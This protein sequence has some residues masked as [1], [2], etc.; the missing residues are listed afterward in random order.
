MVQQ[1]EA[2]ELIRRQ[3][4]FVAERIRDAADAAIG[5]EAQF[6]GNLARERVFEDFAEELGLA[7]Q[8]REEYT[9]IHGRADAVYNRF[10]IEYEPPQSLT[11]YNTSQRNQHA[12]G[13]VRQYIEEL[14]HKERHRVE[15]LAGVA[16]DGC[17]FIFA[18]FRNGVWH[19][20][21]P[22]PVTPASTE[23]FLRYLIS[24]STE[25]AL[26]ADNLVR[27]FGENKTVARLCVSTFYSALATTENPK[28][29]VIYEQWRQQFSE[30]CGFEEGSPRLDVRGLARSY[31][32]Q[33]PKPSA[34]KL[35]F[36]IH[37][38]YATFIKLL[39]VQV[40]HYYLAPKLGTALAQV[41]SY[42]SDRLCSYLKDME[43]GG[44]FRQ[45]GVAN[46]LEGD[47]FGWYL[48]VWDDSVDRAV[49][50][51]IAELSN[52][53][54][55]TLDVDPEQTRDLLKKLYQNVMPK[56][57]RH[58]LGEYYTPDWL[59]ERLL[60]QLG[61]T[62]ERDPELHQRRLL[63]P[64]CGSG[65]F[66][67]LAIKRVKEHCY[68]RIMPEHQILER[69]L[70][71]VVGFDLNPLAVIS[72][73][74]NYLL[75]LGE[76]IQHRREEINIPVY[77]CDSILT[78]WHAEELAGDQYRMK[79]L[80]PPCEFKTV[81]GRFAIPHSL[82]TAQYVDALA[83]LVE[84]CVEAKYSVEDFRRRALQTFPLVEEQ[85][86]SDIELLEKLYSRVKE[87]DEQGVNGIWARIIKNAFA[88]LFQGKFDYVA[89]NPPWVNWQSLPDGY[90]SDTRLLWQYHG[91]FPHGGMDT[92][93][94]KG[95]KDISM[96]M[97]YVSMQ[98][99]L[100]EKGK[101]GFLITQSVFKTAGAGQGFRRFTL[102]DGTPL[103]VLAVDD[104]V[105]LQPFEGAS[106]RTSLVVLE[107][108]K[109]TKYPVTY[110]FWKK[111]GKGVGIGTD[112]PL[113]KVTEVATFKKFYAEP[114]DASDLTSAWIS[115]RSKAL[116]AIRKVLG[117]S[118]Y[119]AHAGAYTGG[120]N[121]VYWI[122]IIARRPDGLVVVSNITEGAKRKVDS[123]Q[124]AIE[125]DLLYPLLRGRDVKRWQ[126][127]PSAYILM[128]Q[129]PV[130]RMG[131]PEDEMKAN[132]PKTYGY[133][134]RFED[135]LRE[136]AAFK[137]YF[138]ESAPFYSMFDVGEY[139]FAA[140][141]VAWPWIAERIRG[142]V[143]TVHGG[144]TMLPEN[145]VTLVGCFSEEE[146]H[147]I[148][149]LLNS[150][151]GDF[152]ARS[153]YATGGGGIARPAVL[154]RIRIPKFNPSD[155]VHSELSALSESAHQAAEEGDEET[156]AAIEERIDELAAQIWG[157]TKAE[158]KE[159]QE[160]LGELK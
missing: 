81:V 77:L 74:A 90:R 21:D 132:Y 10:V 129:D 99:Y 114:V 126:A 110:N 82:V 152:A 66:L 143:V 136:R 55:V 111:K 93:L 130:K 88:P 100:H 142:A 14:A 153:S 91:L 47:F 105:E 12:I 94:G 53:S 46:F 48:D 125:P 86:L 65:T 109:A 61:F 37:S 133:L 101:L 8:P 104:M 80:E 69:I 156:I 154:Q 70:N 58:D 24:L 54:L 149:A 155:K 34:F 32:V 96:L 35:F 25:K 107:K 76:L 22:L 134:K 6:R 39:A 159:I 2:D 52:Y 19:I 15:R 27:D 118:D 157:L 44:I 72:A 5:N 16:T 98:D 97:A 28:I 4:P 41:G 117:Q 119:E 116:R 62:S 146:A 63:D 57:L 33:D 103:R 158:L 67:A 127:E 50:R 75:A 51:L 139:S 121:G 59:A 106:N 23:L 124:A 131:I 89:G 78:P 92:I 43:R 79:G 38:Y 137:R 112:F 140:Y 160:S 7:L 49:R 145:N 108:G 17:F 138:R 45:L 13:Q 128:V 122:E 83:A 150:T 11:K 102:G 123:V 26:T 18:R 144:K 3:A 115:G 147:Y 20:D 71:N 87:L 73:R 148:C 30:V 85:D 120:A 95:K 31:G 64:A 84:E 141:K 42:P 40:V 9:L 151:L 36:A 135:V 1:A 113:E 68:E 29:H 56:E 60:N